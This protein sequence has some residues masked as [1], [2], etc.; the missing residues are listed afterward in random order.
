MP[1]FNLESPSPGIVHLVMDHP[2]RRVNVLDVE[3]LDDLGRALD[4]LSSM[5]DVQGLVL[6]S[7]KNG[8]FIAGADV[9]AIGAIT[10]RD[11]VLRLVRHA[12]QVFG[13]LA[14]LPY[15]TVAAID[16]VC[17]GGGTELALACDSRIASEE[18]RTQI[19][20]PEVLLGI[21]PGFGGSQRLPRLVGLSTA[22]DLILTGRALDARRAEKAGLI[23]RAVPA[24]W[25]L[26]HAHRHLETLARRPAGRRRDLHRPRG[27][28]AWFVDSTPFGRAMALSRARAMTR[29]RTGGHYPAP[30][31]AIDVIERT[32]HLP[33]EAGLEIEASRVSDL[34]IG[35]VCKNLVRI[36]ELSEAAKKEA[37]GSDPSFK[38]QP[39]ERLALVGAGVMGGGIAELASRNGIQVRMRDV[40]AE[41]LT[42]ALRTVRTLID[43]RGRRRRT[44]PRERD[45]QLARILPTLDLSGVGTAGFALEAV[46]EDL[47][48]K[49][50]VLAELEVRVREDCVLA[51]NTSSL[52]VNELA[53]GLA[54]PERL[55]GFHFF[56]P[57]HR[58]PLIEVVKGEQTSDRA[59][60]TAVALARRLGK[61]PVVVQDSPGFV[62]NRI[63]MPY[64]REATWL[65]EEGYAVADIDAAMRRFGMPMGPFE[66]V[67]EV[68]LDVAQKVAGVLS[69]AFPSR[70]TSSPELEK[71]V[72][73]G[74][75]GRKNG[76]GFYRYQGRKR[77]D[78]PGLRHVLGLTRQRKPQTLET[79]SERLV[80]VMVNEA[81]RCLEEGVV[82]DAGKL[83]LAMIFGA[84]FP[85][86]R[87]GLL[88]HA[89]SF[90]LARAEQRL[91]ALRAEKGDRFEPAALLS[92]LVAERGTFTR[93]TV[94]S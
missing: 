59:L 36:F 26:E 93:P 28:G 21:V 40:Q 73:A 61:T 54:H 17:L 27:T 9:E 5:S 89:D 6:R 67:D 74:R 75:L 3:A 15:P 30:V 11:E 65:L 86:F 13:R 64:L 24:A 8:S 22:L 69:R 49:R 45:A 35:P 68:G 72:A 7:G 39:V 43:E 52:S 79:I 4:Q 41:A 14:A 57:V 91:I 33:L 62:V 71:L 58:M 34:V 37:V 46:V 56:N 18:P 55:C 60:V 78:D 63:L 29:A 70:M 44:R 53:R 92:R 42:R 82:A 51:T 48:I 1:V 85:P 31:A 47:E 66:V 81:A 80:L 94:A 19:G 20:L 10:D 12:H 25:L 87:G 2:A 38:P 23:T 32:L 84:G 50:R 90:G 16:G 88:R 83:D 77:L 76:I